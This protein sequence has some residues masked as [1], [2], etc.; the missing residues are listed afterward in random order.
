MGS[1]SFGKVM[2]YSVA[3]GEIPSVVASSYYSR[4][5]RFII[6]LI[7]ITVGKHSLFDRKRFGEGNFKGGG[8]CSPP[9][10]PVGSL[11]RSW[12]ARQCLSVIKLDGKLTLYKLMSASLLYVIL[13]Q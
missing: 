5:L 12:K 8:H 10:R 2:S 3:G 4:G 13:S 7:I 1:R 6:I 9:Q 11:G